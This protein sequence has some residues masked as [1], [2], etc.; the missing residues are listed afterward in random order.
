[1][2]DLEKLLDLGE[3]YAKYVILGS[4]AVLVGLML[5]NIG[6]WGGKGALDAISNLLLAPGRILFMAGFIACGV[7]ADIVPTKVR[8]TSLAVAAILFIK[9][10]V[11]P[12]LSAK[13]GIA[14]ASLM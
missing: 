6:G 8:I 7:A 10:V 14:A 3:N 13:A 12:G 5:Q 1:M 4:A 11:A 9:F 2:L